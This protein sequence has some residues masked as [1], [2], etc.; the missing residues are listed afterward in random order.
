M[1]YVPRQMIPENIED[2][3]LD[4]FCELVAEANIC[5]KMVWD[6]IRVGICK[7]FPEKK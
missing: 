5:R 2:L 3:T 7:A 1:K 4:E 6:D